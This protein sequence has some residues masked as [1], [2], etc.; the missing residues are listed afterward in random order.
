MAGSILE[1]DR[2]LNRIKRIYSLIL[3]NYR[4]LRVDFDRTHGL[5]RKIT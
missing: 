3:L 1:K 5:K 2:G 4:G